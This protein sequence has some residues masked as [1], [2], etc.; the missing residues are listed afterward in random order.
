MCLVWSGSSCVILY[1]NGR[2]K[3]CERLCV[4]R[5][6]TWCHLFISRFLVQ[7]RL[8][9]RIFIVQISVCLVVR[10]WTALSSALSRL[11]NEIMSMESTH[12]H[13]HTLDRDTRQDDNIS[14]RHKKLNLNFCC[15]AR[16]EWNSWFSYF[17][18]GVPIW[19]LYEPNIKTGSYLIHF[20][21]PSISPLKSNNVWDG[22]CIRTFE[23]VRI[24]HFA[25]VSLGVTSSFSFHIPKID[26]FNIILW[27]SD[28]SA[29]HTQSIIIHN[30]L[31]V[32]HPCQLQCECD[33]W[34]SE[35]FRSQIWKWEENEIEKSG[36]PSCTVMRLL[37][38]RWRA[39][40]M[41]EKRG[42]QTIHCVVSLH[43]HTAKQDLFWDRFKLF[44]C[45][46]YR[47]HANGENFFC[48]IQRCFSREAVAFSMNENT[49]FVDDIFQR[50]L[51]A[52]NRMVVYLYTLCTMR[53]T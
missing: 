28:T 24:L 43:T 27:W 30:R 41:R 39:C 26:T 6:V 9:E 18:F 42:I 4:S 16:C 13:I 47:T 33:F 10:Q 8:V 40:T 14:I 45:A 49:P 51:N 36:R 35:I 46:V 25:L 32:A 53:R 29:S 3:L 48:T 5:F 7:I 38:R 50:T 23:W 19:S 2:T 12:T 52:I 31:L 44:Y 15:S 37:R 22:N 17:L 1:T 20:Y 11:T 21:T 34:Q